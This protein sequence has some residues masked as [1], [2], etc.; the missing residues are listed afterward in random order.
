[1]KCPQ[2]GHEASTYLEDGR[3]FVMCIACGLHTLLKLIHQYK[4]NYG[5]TNTQE[6]QVR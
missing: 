2:C 6:Q 5:N 4:S 1:M 3:Y